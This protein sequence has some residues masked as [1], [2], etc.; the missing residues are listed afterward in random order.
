[1]QLNATICIKKQ[2]NPQLYQ[3][4]DMKC[5]KSLRAVFTLFSYKRNVYNFDMK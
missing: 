4:F 5:S 2:N 1:M 3:C